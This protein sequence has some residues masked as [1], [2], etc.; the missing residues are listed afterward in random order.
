[1][2]FAAGGGISANPNVRRSIRLECDNS[3]N[4]S[5]NGSITMKYAKLCEFVDCSNGICEHDLIRFMKPMLQASF[6]LQPP[7]DTPTRRSTFDGILAGCIPVFFEELSAKK[8]Y[9]WHLPEEKYE[10]FSV[11]I[12]KEEMVFKGLKI[13]DVLM[14]IPRAEVRRM[15]EKVLEM[16]PRVMYRKHGSSIGLRSKKDAFDIAIDGTLQRIK[17]RLEVIA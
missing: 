9:K 4:V 16:I 3:T 1:M 8:Q 10:E 6:C 12:P 15:R 5:L 17:S 2:L 7:G 11:F 13:L 14:S